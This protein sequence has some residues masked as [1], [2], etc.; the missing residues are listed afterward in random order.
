MM[1]K[2]KIIEII[3]S[4]PRKEIA[5]L[6]GV[7]KVTIYR[8]VNNE[9]EPTVSHIEKLLEEYST[10]SKNATKVADTLNMSLDYLTRSEKTPT[11]QKKSVSEE[12]Q[13]FSPSTDDTLGKRIRRAILEKGKSINAF[14]LDIGM[15][16]STLSSIVNDEERMPRIDI[17]HKIAHALHVP[18]EYLVTGKMPDPSNP[19]MIMSVPFGGPDVKIPAP[20]LRQDVG[21]PIYGLSE[22]GPGILKSTHLQMNGTK[23]MLLSE[24]AYIVITIGDSLTPMGINPGMMCYCEPTITPIRGDIV[25]I[26]RNDDVNLLK[27]FDEDIEISGHKAMAVTGWI[28]SEQGT[29]EDFAPDTAIQPSKYVAEKMD[30]DLT[31]V[32]SIATVIYVKR[33]AV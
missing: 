33:K 4:Y 3:N 26:I 6:L 24:K 2:K 18:V 21:L 17:V 14:A 23:E 31:Q 8:W 16:Q 7:N 5:S 20:S 27:R 15:K 11:L 1:L 13:D 19:R 12:A 9:A 32:K 29:S 25:H 10:K 30:I 22:C 28:E